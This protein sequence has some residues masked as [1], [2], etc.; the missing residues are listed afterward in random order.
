M[1][2]DQ[3]KGNSSELCIKTLSPKQKSL[4]AT[5]HLS[6]PKPRQTNSNPLDLYR[7]QTETKNPTTKQIQSQLSQ[8]T[9]D[10]K[11]EVKV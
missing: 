3:K 1:Q 6:F 8:E 5:Q 4:R 10:E 9:E 11:E 2:E 7:N